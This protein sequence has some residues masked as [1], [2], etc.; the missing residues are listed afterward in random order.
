MRQLFVFLISTL[1]LAVLVKRICGVIMRMKFLHIIQRCQIY[2]RLMPKKEN[3]CDKIVRQY[4]MGS[5]SMLVKWTLLK[6]AVIPLHFHSNE[7]PPGQPKASS[8]CITR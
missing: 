3:I 4:I 6:G 7:Q 8:G 1:P 5:N 2:T